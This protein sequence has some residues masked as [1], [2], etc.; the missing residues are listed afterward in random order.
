MSRNLYS[1]Q[2]KVY[3]SHNLDKK[4]KIKED[5]LITNYLYIKNMILTQIR[6]NR[7]GHQDFIKRWRR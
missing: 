1:T 2:I 7:Y 3:Y 6:L 5:G 4:N